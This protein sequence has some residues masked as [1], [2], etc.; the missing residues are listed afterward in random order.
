MTAGFRIPYLMRI[1]LCH[2][3]LL[4]AVIIIS[5]ILR[6]LDPTALL[7]GGIFMGL[8]FLLMALGIGW[9]LSPAASKSRQRIGIILLGL[10]FFL[11]LGLVSALFFRMNL[12]GVSFVV[13][14]SSLLVASVVVTLSSG[15]SLRAT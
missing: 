5:Q 8:N 3:L 1:E 2:A 9:V 12:D 15:I 13:G 14:V 6:V 11:F 10:K 4:L 7:L